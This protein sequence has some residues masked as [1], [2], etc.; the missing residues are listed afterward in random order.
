M[1]QG[2]FSRLL[3]SGLCYHECVVQIVAFG[4]EN[5]RKLMAMIEQ[6]RREFSQP[7]IGPVGVH[8]VRPCF[9]SLLFCH[10]RSL[11]WAKRP[12]FPRL[13]IRTSSPKARP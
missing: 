2:S 5:V 6:R 7:P 9:A 11:I 8:V 4:G 3:R 12:C 10:P 1:I 13:G